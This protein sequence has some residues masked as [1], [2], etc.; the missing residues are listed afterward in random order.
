[1]SPR[2]A[3]AVVCAALGTML[4][5][6]NLAAPLYASYQE[7][8]GFS[9][10]T[11]TLVFATYA[12]VL[13]P[14]LMIFGKLSDHVGRRPVMLCGLTAA[15]TGLVLFAVAHGLVWLYAARVVQGVAVGM[16]T[17]TATAALVELEPDEG[18]HRPAL[19]SAVAQAGGSSAGPI[20]GGV[21]AES[22][23]DPLV[24][25]F[26]SAALVVGVLGVLV[27]AVPETSRGI[28]TP[29]RLQAPG[30]PAD[31]RASFARVAITAAA[32]WG[33]AGLYLSV[34]P[35]Y[36]TDITGM[37]N[38]AVIGL[39]AAVMPLASCAAQVLSRGVSS[40]ATTQAAGLGLLA[41]GLVG[42]VAA[43]PTGL[44]SV[45]VAGAVLSGVGHGIAF[46]A[47]Q[48][49]LN[50]IAPPERRGEVTAAFVTCIYLG[51]SVSAIGVGVLADLASLSVGVAAFGVVTGT[52]ALAVAAWHLLTDRERGHALAG[53]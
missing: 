39:L 20:A 45:L 9:S 23:P 29:W 37:T 17:G 40:A 22:A 44:V 27:L 15:L 21:L 7:K 12:V 49:D 24:T 28:G 11:L 6:V 32:V 3:L 31:I 16:T 34:V 13:I 8:F 18:S 1:M 41:L 10:L 47:A 38:L 25:P 50:T 4:A 53:R 33:V 51:V 5:S 46:L 42:L 19:L 43:A 52:A 2:L 26:V 14:S 36:V 48:H 35:S 30:V